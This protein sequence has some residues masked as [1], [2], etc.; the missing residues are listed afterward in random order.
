MP[1]TENAIERENT[2][3][4]LLTQGEVLRMLGISEATFVRR[5]RSGGAMPSGIRLGN[6]LRYRRK[7]VLAWLDSIVEK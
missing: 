3:D 6:H 4:R 7:D 2:E 5:R 1:Q